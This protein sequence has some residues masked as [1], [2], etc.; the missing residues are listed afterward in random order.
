MVRFDWR[1]TGESDRN[2]LPATIDDLVADIDAVIR[3][4]PGPVDALYFGTVCFAGLS[5]AARHPSHYRSIY[6]V[7]GAL[8]Q[9]GNRHGLNN[10]PG[11]EKNYLEHL[12]GL[13]LLTLGVNQAEAFSLAAG[14]QDAVPREAYAAYLAVQQDIDLTAVLPTIS[15]PALVSASVPYDYESAA[16]M[17]ALL[18]DA[19]LSLMPPLDAQDIPRVRRDDWDR[20]LGSRFGEPPSQP[21]AAPPPMAHALDTLS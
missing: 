9:G 1:G 17:A 10:R 21:L 8:R 6:V 14:W 11:W 3:V 16:L 20:H 2:R 18:P 7:G 12:R 4:A 19:T 15:I 5:H 13:A